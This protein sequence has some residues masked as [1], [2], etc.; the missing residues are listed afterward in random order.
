[1]GDIDAELTI[2]KNDKLIDQLK[3]ELLTTINGRVYDTIKQGAKEFDL[4]YKKER[5]KA[6]EQTTN[7][8]DIF[9]TDLNNS[10]FNNITIEEAYYK[11]EKF[12]KEYE[13]YHGFFEAKSKPLPTI[14]IKEVYK[15]PE[16]DFNYL[17]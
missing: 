17:D 2:I 7:L 14:K 3:T 4:L 8:S 12:F 1:M 9:E 15:Y 10:I 11:G 16:I 13:K 5:Q 6:T